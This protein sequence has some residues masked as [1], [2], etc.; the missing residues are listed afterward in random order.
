MKQ[1]KTIQAAC[2][3][4]RHRVQFGKCR[5]QLPGNNG[6]DKNDTAIIQDATRL[7]LQMWVLPIIDAISRGDLCSLNDSLRMNYISDEE[8]RSLEAEINQ[9]AYK[10]FI[11]T[12]NDYNQIPDN[13]GTEGI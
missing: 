1:S 12:G 10:P 3:L 5:L 8:I 11:G 9:R 13:N 2:K 4:L 6:Y 7:Y